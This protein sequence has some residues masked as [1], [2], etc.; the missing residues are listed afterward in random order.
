MCIETDSEFCFGLSACGAGV[1][2]QALFENWLAT[3]DPSI[4]AKRKRKSTNDDREK[5]MFEAQDFVQVT[6]CRIRDANKNI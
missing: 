2:N 6:V 4:N 5:S 3:N 1:G